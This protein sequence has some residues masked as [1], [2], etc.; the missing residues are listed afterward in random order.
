[1]LYE[2]REGGENLHEP[3]SGRTT[4]DESQSC[5]FCISE[6]MPTNCRWIFKETCMNSAASTPLHIKVRLVYLASQNLCRI[7]GGT[8]AVSNVRQDLN[9]IWQAIYGLCAISCIFH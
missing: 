3:C 7:C 5:A 6:L 8:F 2:F 9:F 4:T 1:M